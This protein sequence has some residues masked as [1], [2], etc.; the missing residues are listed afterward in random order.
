[1]VVDRAKLALGL[2]RHDP[3]FEAW[4]AA[5][6][7]TNGVIIVSAPS[8]QPGHL[9]AIPTTAGTGSESF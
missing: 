1:M 3:G 8:Q 2:I 9:V 5:R 7:V 6:A 4:L